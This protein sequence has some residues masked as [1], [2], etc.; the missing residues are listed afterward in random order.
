VTS[1]IFATDG[2]WLGGDRCIGRRRPVHDDNPALLD[3]AQA[4]GYTQDDLPQ[5][6]VLVGHSLGGGS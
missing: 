1:N 5:N 4:A 2:M 6:V 3:S